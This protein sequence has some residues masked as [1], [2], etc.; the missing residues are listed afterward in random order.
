MITEIEIRERRP[1]VGGASFGDTGSYIR[2]DGI[3]R[4]EVDPAHPA[5]RIIANVDR[6]PRNAR[7]HVEY[8]SDVCIIRP[9]TAGSGNG[10]LLYEVNNR[11]RKLLFS[12]LC[13]GAEGNNPQTAADVGNAL[14][15]RMGFS[16]VWSG[17]DASAPRANGGLAMEAPIAGSSDA[18]VVERIREEF[19]SGSR[20]GNLTAFRLA[21]EAASLDPRQATLTVRR[22]RSAEAVLVEDW[23]FVD[24]RTIRLLP[25]DTLPE[26][27]SIYEILYMAT[28]PRVLG[29]GFAATRDLVSYLRHAPAGQDLLGSA[30]T[31][32]L[33]FGIS[34]SGRYLRTH[35]AL[36]FNR[37]EEGHRLFDGVMAHVAGI[38][39]VFLHQPFSQPGRTRTRHED[40]D[41]PEVEFPFASAVTTD[42]ISGA[43]DSLMRRDG[44]DPVLIET[45][46]ST[47][48]WQ[49]GA[50]LLHTTPDG[51]QDLALPANVRG[52]LIAGTQHG[53]R[54]NMASE[55]GATI[56]SSNWH[57]P[58]PALR[59]LLVALDRWVAHGEM[60]PPSRL[61]RIDNGTLTTVDKLAFPAIPGL[62]LPRDANDVSPPA[63]WTA[64]QPA[65]RSYCA[66]VPQ[67][68]ADGNELAGIRL[69]DIAVPRGTHTGWN[70]YKAP[71]PEDELADRTGSFIA[72]APTFEERER[73]HDPRPSIAERYANPA[74]YAAKVEAAVRDLV[75]DRLLL[76]E[77]AGRFIRRA[78]G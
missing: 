40:H 12:H 45:N 42:P 1:F 43:T 60:P 67:V 8:C 15:L 28:K 71:M 64:P 2:L 72:F 36:G 54:A 39:R 75:Q 69:P 63:D 57:D 74:D 46:S 5:N 77:D 41:F 30:P 58:T 16:L 19:V 27:G 48:Y 55:S 9:A 4:G 49:K 68:D 52:Y 73:S 61:P 7:G 51:E 21:Y 25:T 29:L 18:P 26:P 17:W 31:H 78:R 38:G 32:A 53:G 59:A 50:S 22:T 11:G 14:P 70:L 37:D 20:A 62:R 66:L 33:A 35:L 23:E 34:Q 6:A 44:S 10:R 24:P 13:S 76:E 47:E 3:A 65:V 56:N